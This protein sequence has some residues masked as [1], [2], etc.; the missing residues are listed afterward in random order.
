M[1]E[2]V[3]NKGFFPFCAKKVEDAQAEN[4]RYNNFFDKGFGGIGKIYP[5]GM[6]LKDAM[7]LYWKLK[8]IEWDF[9]GSWDNSSDSCSLYSERSSI[10]PYWCYDNSSDFNEAIFKPPNLKE[11]ASSYDILRK[12]GC[13]EY[14][15][16]K[17]VFRPDFTNA[18][19]GPI[20]YYSLAEGPEEDPFFCQNFEE[21]NEINE[22]PMSC[23]FRPCA[24]QGCGDE[25]NPEF[26][27]VLYNESNQL[28]YPSLFCF[29]W[30]YS[31]L[32]T[33]QKFLAQDYESEEIDIVTL[34]INDNT[35]DITLYA[36]YN[37]TKED[38][39][40]STQHGPINCYL[41]ET[42]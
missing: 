20:R 17:F 8:Y 39:P 33:T 22:S 35:Y 40:P 9:F 21:D 29:Y 2:F 23:F 25:R 12:R 30:T 42:D 7:A 10:G 15:P 36:V 19:F 37:Y 1:A 27:R 4:D 16:D 11:G 41:A 18:M 28:Y 32:W 14:L 26:A 6:P 31:R 24:G 38:G 13:S 34:N 5:I 3:F